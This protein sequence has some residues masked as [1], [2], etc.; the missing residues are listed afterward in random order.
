MNFWLFTVLVTGNGLDFT[1]SSCMRSP[2]TT[3]GIIG[4][5]GGSEGGV[6]AGFFLVGGGGG[7]TVVVAVFLGA[8]HGSSLFVRRSWWSL[9]TVC[10]FLPS[11]PVVGFVVLRLLPISCSFLPLPMIFRLICVVA[12]VPRAVCHRGVLRAVFFHFFC[13]SLSSRPCHPFGLLPCFP[14]SAPCARYCGQSSP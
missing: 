13:M 3:G 4:F 12:S 6:V 8:D 14:L 7:E 2:G 11:D 9:S 1:P 5:S 10:S